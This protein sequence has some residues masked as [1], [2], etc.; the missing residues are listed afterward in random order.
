MAGFSNRGAISKQRSTFEDCTR[1]RSASNPQPH[2]LAQF[3]RQL[4]LD[5]AAHLVRM[6]ARA[7]MTA[8]DQFVLEAVGPFDEV[9]QV[10]VTELVDLLTAMVRTNETHLRD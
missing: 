1:P 9:V 8:H 6:I 4:C 2:L 10:H 3:R 7:E 5:D